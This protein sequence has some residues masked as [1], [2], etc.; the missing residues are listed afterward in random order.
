MTNRM[1]N[2]TGWLTDKVHPSW[3]PCLDRRTRNLL[4]DIEM[5]VGT[6]HYPEPFHVLRFLQTDVAL[7]KVA[8]LGQ[9]PYPGAGA[10][11][12][13][14]FEVGNLRTWQEPFRQ[15]S[16]KNIL[17]LL[18]CVRH[19]VRPYERDSEYGRIPS[20]SEIRRSIEE[21]S[22]TIASPRVLFTSWEEQGV[23]LL[24]TA[25]TVLPGKPGTHRELWAPFTEHVLQFLAAQRPD[26]SWFLWGSHAQAYRSL[27]GHASI[28]ASR[29]PMLCS[30]SYPDD[31]LKNPCFH[32][33]ADSVD[34]LGRPDC[35]VPPSMV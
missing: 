22:F 3:E 24:N 8:I 27:L 29:H 4:S 32:E 19:D 14:A 26:L 21:N 35:T 20:F 34:W 33:T 1:N 30:G 9:D 16:L 5:R 25:L 15:V 10:A 7:L 18:W 2:P 12:G 13:R 17:R 31:F 28:H 6:V 23:L 11:T